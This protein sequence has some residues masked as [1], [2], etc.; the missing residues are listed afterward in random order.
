MP[1]PLP[2]KAALASLIADLPLALH[3]YTDTPTLFCAVLQVAPA[4][5]LPQCMAM[6][7]PVVRGAGRGSRQMGTPTANMDPAAVAA[8]LRDSPKGVYFGCDSCVTMHDICDR[9]CTCVHGRCCV[10]MERLQVGPA[11]E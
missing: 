4:Y 10:D 3:A 6:T 7:A 5:A 2:D 9:M 8:A 11:A 1:H